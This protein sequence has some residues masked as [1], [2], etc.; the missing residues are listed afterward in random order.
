MGGIYDIFILADFWS[1][2]G[3]I[4]AIAAQKINFHCPEIGKKLIFAE[5]I[6]ANGG[7]LRIL[8]G[9]FENNS[10]LAQVEGLLF[11]DF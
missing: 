7:L 6:F 2:E 8:R 11:S 10:K 5:F 9:I 1:F 3:P 4:F